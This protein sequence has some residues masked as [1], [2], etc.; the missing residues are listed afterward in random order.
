MLLAGAI[1][2][3]FFLVKRLNKICRLGVI[4]EAIASFKFALVLENALSEKVA[5]FFACV[6]G[7]FDRLIDDWK[8]EKLQS[9]E[10]NRGVDSKDCLRTNVDGFSR[11]INVSGWPRYLSCKLR[12]FAP[13]VRRHF[14]THVR[15]NGRF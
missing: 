5:K 10:N 14:A 8:F 9:V 1:A 6:N 12:A 13:H 2:S 7:F 15:C 4:V 11:A 3:R